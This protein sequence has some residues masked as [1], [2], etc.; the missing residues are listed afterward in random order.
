DSWVTDNHGEEPSIQ[1]T[2]ESSPSRITSSPS[3]SPYHTP[4]SAPSISQLPSIQTTPVA[5]E[6]APMPHESP[7]QSVHS[8]GR[9]KGS[10]CWE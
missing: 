10:L 8:L 1:T 5:E 9:D 4:I 2:P 6:A 7:L 3:L